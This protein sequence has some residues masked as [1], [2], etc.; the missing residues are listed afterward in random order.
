MFTTSHLTPV[1]PRLLPRHPGRIP[2]VPPCVPQVGRVTHWAI[3]TFAGISALCILAFA[4]DAHYFWT[5][6]SQSV[7]DEGELEKGL[8]T[9]PQATCQSLDRVLQQAV[10]P[11]SSVRLS[12]H[13]AEIQCLVRD[14]VHGVQVFSNTGQNQWREPDA[15]SSS[16]F[17]QQGTVPNH[18]IRGARSQRLREL[19]V[20]V[21]DL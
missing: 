6:Y 16:D 13:I 20:I 15:N 7:I 19:F 4:A 18:Q 12:P 17:F 8:V 11:H 10:P 9:T 3:D 14:F 2:V 21:I 1:T 5:R